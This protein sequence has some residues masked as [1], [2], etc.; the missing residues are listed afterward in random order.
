MQSIFI[1]QFNYA[2]GMMTVGLISVIIPN[3]AAL[4]K[5]IGNLSGRRII[6][7]DLKVVIVNELHCLETILTFQEDDASQ[8][9]PEAI[10]VWYQ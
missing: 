5:E 3:R 8:W 2:R 7:Q 6:K 4:I 10:D 1:H 9:T